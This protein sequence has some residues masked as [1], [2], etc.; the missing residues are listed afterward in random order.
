MLFAGNLE[1]ITQT[2][3]MAIYLGFERNLGIAI[4]LP[5]VLI[6]FSVILLT[7][8]H[9]DGNRSPWGVKC[10]RLTGGEPLVR[11]HIVEIVR[12][13]ASIPNILNMNPTS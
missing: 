12:R 9:C 6:S 8:T 10:V 2:M 3:P 5:V 4:A 1:G 13:I 7:I 11:P